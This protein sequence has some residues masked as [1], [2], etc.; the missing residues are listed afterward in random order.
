MQENNQTQ[1]L[2]NVRR[3]LG[4][5]RSRADILVPD[6]TALSDQHDAVTARA[7]AIHRELLD[8]ADSLL[9][10]LEVSAVE[11]GWK[12]VRCQSNTEAADYISKLVQ[13]LEARAIVRTAHPNVE[14][15]ELED[16]MSPLGIQVELMATGEVGVEELDERRRQFRQAGIDADIGITGV[17]YAIVETG[18]CVLLAKKGVSRLASLLPPVHVA[19][20]EKGQVL[21]SLDELFTLLRNDSLNGEELRYMN[22]ITGPSRSADIESTLVTGV[23]GPGEVHMVLIG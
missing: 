17:D 3:A 15:L 18:T 5:D 2:D 14:S 21:P 10:R 16:R 11:A 13:N 6:V 4:K 7:E 23:H 19:L 20:V 9:A 8:D 1:F 22:L 12:V